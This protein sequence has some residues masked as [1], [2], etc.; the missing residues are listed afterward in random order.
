M[1]NGDPDVGVQIS[2]AIF[3]KKQYN[4]YKYIYI[5]KG[6]KYN[7]KN[8]QP[9]VVSCDDTLVCDLPFFL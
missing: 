9:F 5:F 4:E 3:V 8:T 1:K 7:E 2:L 6:G